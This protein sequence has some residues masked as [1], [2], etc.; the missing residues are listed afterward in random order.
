M[1]LGNVL[2]GGLLLG[3]AKQSFVAVADPCGATVVILLEDRS[4][5]YLVHGS[6]YRADGSIERDK[7]RL[8]AKS[9]TQT[10]GLD[11]SETFSL[12]AKI[13]IVR[14]LLAIATMKDWHLTQLDVNDAFLLGDLSEEVYMVL[15]PGFHVKGGSQFKHK[16]IGKLKYF[17]SL[18]VTQSPAC[19]SLCQRKY[20]LEILQDAGLLASKLVAF[21]MEQNIKLSKDVGDLLADPRVYRRLVGRLLYLTL[22]RPDLCYSINRLSQYMVQRRQPH[23]QEA[24]R[25]LQYIKGTPGHG[26]FFSAANSLSLKGFTDSDWASCLDTRRSTSGYCVVLGDSLV[27]WKTKKQ[28]TISISSTEAKY[29]SMAYTTCDIIW[30][31]TLLFDFGISH[32]H[33]A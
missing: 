12:V 22:T 20:F 19:I 30:F 27:S 16:D 23:L 24:S 8:V 4:K 9:N 28:T 29:K 7:T 5:A 14:T 6:L 31:L 10:E 1:E 33:S 15:P 11:Y 17:L 2:V 13:A 32:T 21:P 18:E 26:L 3:V 25:I